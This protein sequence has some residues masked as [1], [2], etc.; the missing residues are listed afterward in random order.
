[1]QVDVH[2]NFFIRRSRG[3]IEYDVAIL[4]LKTAID[5]GNDKFKHIRP[6]CLGDPEDFLIDLTQRTGVVAGWGATEVTYADTPCGYRKG[7]VNPYTLSSC[8]KKVDGLSFP[9]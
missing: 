8:L 3:K 6:I 2:P 1:M 5:F 9:P 7:V 4:T